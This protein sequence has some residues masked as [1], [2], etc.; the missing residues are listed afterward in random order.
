MNGEQIKNALQLVKKNDTD[1]RHVR[2]SQVQHDTRKVTENTCFVCIVGAVVDGHQLADEAVAKGATLIVA[3]KELSVAVPVLYVNDTQKA[4]AQLSV[5]ATGN[6]SS[7]LGMVGVTGT[8]GKTTITHV[9]AS[10]LDDNNRS[11]GIIGTMYSKIGDRQIPVANTTPDSLTTQQLLADMVADGLTHCTMEASS[12]ALIQGRVRG[13]DFDVA[14]FTNLTQDHLEYHHTME[15][16][17]LAKSLLFSQL[18]NAYGEQGKQKLAVINIDD[19]YGER[20]IPLTAANVLTYGCQGRGDIQAQNVVVT[21][22]GTSFD[23]LFLGEIYPVT[24][25]MI[26]DFNVYNILAAF[27]ACY[28]LGLASEAII[29]SIAKIE[30]V[31]GRFQLVPNHRG[32]TAIV[33]YAH[34]PDGLENVLKTINKFAEGAVYCVVGCG[35][36]RDPSKRPVMAD[37][38]MT[39]ATHPVFTS[40]NPRTEDPT[41]IIKQMT[42]HLSGNKYVEIVERREAIEYALSKAEKHDVV[43]I[44]GKG[45]EDYQII[46]TTKHHFDDVEIVNDYFAKH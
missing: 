41:E 35:G 19:A 12:H 23:L 24:M 33:D 39:Y 6:P 34:T 15:E 30:G 16:Y 40:D 3:E 42:R 11:S 25:K 26:G 43:L 36:D 37:V 8:N 32:V 18:G 38:A 7:K 44:A 29:R 4:L 27:G 5:L 13:I 10:I 20:L 2:V 31:K 9:V 28:G 17:F 21:N 22:H 46:G 14:V 45:H 1:L